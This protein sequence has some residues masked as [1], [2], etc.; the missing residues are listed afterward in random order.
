VSRRRPPSTLALSTAGVAAVGTSFG[1]ARYGYGLL[2]PDIRADLGLDSG[3]LGA[4][5]AGGAL[6]YLLATATGAAL[7]A[8]LGPRATVLAGGSLATAGMLLAGLSRGPG[9][10]A[11]GVILAGASAG[12]VFP[13]FADAVAGS[14]APERR[15]RVLAA[16]SSGTGYGVAAAAPIAVATGSDWH[17][18]WILFALVAALSTAGA[19]S[20]L[21]RAAPIAGAEPVRLRWSWFVCPRSRPLLLGALVVGLGSSVYWTFGV[22]LLVTEGAVPRGSAGLLLLVVGIASVLGTG[23][24]DLVRRVGARGAFTGLALAL[25]AALALLGLEPGSPLVATF[26]ALLFGAAY[27]GIVAIQ[28]IW[29]GLVFSE[30]PSAGLAGVMFML[31]LGLLVGPPAAGLVASVAPLAD[32]FVGA[33]ALIATV[34][35]LAP[36]EALRPEPART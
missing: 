35:V 27:N 22:D 15:G 19:T 24:G 36:R 7:A 34:A 9:L 6:A 17:L 21:P 26:S 25:G 28:G 16:I 11:A 14:V 12:L 31:G 13:P 4:L 23:A 5:A 3:A 32:A 1:M 30:R 20:V 8:R 2:L 18:T 29:S 33:G 10:L